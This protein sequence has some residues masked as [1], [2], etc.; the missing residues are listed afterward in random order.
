MKTVTMLITMFTLLMSSP[1]IA[2][3]HGHAHDE[4]GA[5]HDE[6]GGEFGVHNAHQKG[7]HVGHDAHENHAGHE[8]GG[9][10]QLTSAQIKQAGIEIQILNLRPKLQA[11]HAPGS[12][13]F[14]A[15]NLADVTTLVDSVV[16]ARHVRLG[17]TVKKGQALVTLASSELAQAEAAYL[18]S[19]AEHR[20]SKL[21]LKR[22]ESLVKEKIIS[23]ARFQQAFSIHQAAHA[24]LA[25]A[26][27]ALASYGISR[28]II[29]TLINLNQYGQL[30]LFAPSS[31]TVVADDFRTGQHIAAGTRLL[32]IADE[33][34][35]WIEVKLSQ[36]QMQ[37]VN[38]GRSAIVSTKDGNND[39][40]GKVVNIH[41]QLDPI[42]R[43]VGVRLEVRNPED[44]LHPGMF[45]SAEIETG[46]GEE[47]LLLPEQAIQRQGSELIVFVEEEPEHFE[48]REVRA[49]KASMGLV[50]ILEGVKVGESVVIKGAFV[51][52]SELAKAGFEVH[53]H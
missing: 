3:E 21:D 16:H 13:T 20:K 47:V 18:R 35:V 12:V 38:V 19:E 6:A 9:S 24:N 51:L 46:S 7:G 42:T 10:I 53:N 41:H 52:A 44:E 4:S 31:G 23:Q 37:G 28:E 45:V 5:G 26:R 29:D 48:R 34:T 1:V 17:D 22:L 43:T 50:P 39:Y 33:S 36:S 49:G 14:N 8:E 11:I 25:A 2:G 27:A 30:T 40:K 32:Q 15:Y